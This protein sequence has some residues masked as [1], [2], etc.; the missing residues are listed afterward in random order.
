M[1]RTRK[2]LEHMVTYVLDTQ[3]PKVIERYARAL[4]QLAEEHEAETPR[5]DHVPSH[6][7][8]RTSTSMIRIGN[9]TYE[10]QN[11]TIRKNRIYIDGQRVFS[12]RI[13]ELIARANEENIIIVEGDVKIDVCEFDL[14][15]VGDVHSNQL[16]VGGK[17]LTDQVI[18]VNDLVINGNVE[19][20][21]TTVQG[22]LLLHGQSNEL[23]QVRVEGDLE[24][25]GNTNIDRNRVQGDLNIEGDVSIEENH[26]EGSM[27]VG[28][29]KHRN[30][31]NTGFKP[32][33]RFKPMR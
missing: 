20:E 30:T 24:I 19:I 13:E 6:P 26:V 25:Y 8:G 33:E 9:E 7:K 23:D 27:H 15:V 10:G 12:S 22:H 28:S 18:T 17:L 4:E 11:L 21:R 32:A 1:R 31:L 3:D 2:E 14:E 5:I 29:S 16:S